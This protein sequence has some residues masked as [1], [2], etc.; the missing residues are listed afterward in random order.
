M[1]RLR[2]CGGGHLAAVAETAVLGFLDDGLEG[3]AEGLV[4]VVAAEVT[5]LDE[6]LEGHAADGTSDIGGG[7]RGGFGL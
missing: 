1:V 3:L 7:F 4:V 5:F 2:R 6:L